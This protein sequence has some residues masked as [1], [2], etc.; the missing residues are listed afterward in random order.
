[1]FVYDVHFLRNGPAA[2]QDAIAIVGVDQVVPEDIQH[3]LRALPHVRY[4]KV[5]EFPR[6]LPLPHFLQRLRKI[7]SILTP[8]FGFCSDE[9]RKRSARD[10]PPEQIPVL[11]ERHITSRSLGIFG[12]PRVNVL[13]LNLALRR[14]YRR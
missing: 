2:N 4:V 14:A 9:R 7:Y 13:E 5:L 3:K 6:G 11:V 10:V 1:M 8:F 12:E